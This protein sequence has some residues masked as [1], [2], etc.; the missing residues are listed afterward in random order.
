MYSSL[1][2]YFQVMTDSLDHW[3]RRNLLACWL[4]VLSLQIA[5]VLGTIAN[6]CKI[7][8]QMAHKGTFWWETRLTKVTCVLHMVTGELGKQMCL[9]NLSGHHALW[10]KKFMGGSRSKSTMQRHMHVRM[11]MPACRLWKRPFPRISPKISGARPW[12]A[13]SLCDSQDSIRIVL[14][15]LP[16]RSPAIGV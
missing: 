14:L 5:G 3:W 12:P 7:F 4:S 11:H 6:C 15:K 16:G 2:F 10:Y 9:A 1:C 13:V 8:W